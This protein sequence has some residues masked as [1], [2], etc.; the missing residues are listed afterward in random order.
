MEVDKSLDEDLL[1]DVVISDVSTD[2]IHESPKN[3]P[4]I[5]F[6]KH[7][8]NVREFAAKIRKIERKIMLGLLTDIEETKLRSSKYFSKR[9]EKLLNLSNN[10]KKCNLYK[11][12]SGISL[13]V[14]MVE[15]LQKKKAGPNVRKKIQTKINN[16]N[17]RE[18]VVVEKVA[19]GTLSQNDVDSFLRD[20]YFTV[21]F[22]D[23]LLD[24]PISNQVI[25]V[26]FFSYT[27]VFDSLTL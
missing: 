13:N 18:K 8:K 25:F 23:V 27:L 4:K 26:S 16:L 6:S 20:M 3:V 2:S 17:I 15:E 9:F 7:P 14:Q 1:S 12:V 24:H 5:Q 11:L 19:A 21:H 10:N 22:G